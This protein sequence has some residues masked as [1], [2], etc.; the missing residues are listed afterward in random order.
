MQSSTEASEAALDGTHNQWNCRTVHAFQLQHCIGEAGFC[1]GGIHES[2]ISRKGGS[3]RCDSDVRVR[4]DLCD[5]AD[6]D[7]RR[8][9]ADSLF[10]R[11]DRFSFADRR[12]IYLPIVVGVLVWIGV[13]LREGRLPALVPL[14]RQPA[15]RGRGRSAACMKTARVAKC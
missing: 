14:R 9:P 6:V 2:G 12:T 7:S 4:R 3:G 11:G 1:P 8:D 5:S 15:W 10:G 13:Y